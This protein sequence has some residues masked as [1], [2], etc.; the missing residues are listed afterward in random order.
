MD[1]RN[2][3]V[4]LEFCICAAIQLG[5][6]YIVRGHRHNDCLNTI[7]D[8]R[9]AGRRVGQV[10]DTKQGFITSRGRFVGREEA[11]ALQKAAGIPSAAPGGYRGKILFSQDLY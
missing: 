4:E 8:L 1:L 5:D 10:S 3:C 7:Y 11:L 9:M 6:G 2:G